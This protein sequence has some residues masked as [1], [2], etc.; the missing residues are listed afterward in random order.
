MTPHMVLACKP[1]S[2]VTNPLKSE[3]DCLRHHLLQRTTAQINSGGWK[4]ELHH[5]LTDMPSDVSKDTDI[6]FW[7]TV[8]IVCLFLML[9]LKIALGSL[10]RLSNTLSYCN[11]CTV[12]AIL[13]TYICTLQAPLLCWC[14]NCHQ[15]P[16]MPWCREVWATSSTQACL[17]RLDCQHCLHQYIQCRRGIL[18]WIQRASYTGSAVDRLG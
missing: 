12:C 16:I 3:Y 2:N 11:G 10:K 4:E 8:C 18:G 1:K 17:A 5:Y 13:A 7:W 14:W 15:P 6:V 9:V